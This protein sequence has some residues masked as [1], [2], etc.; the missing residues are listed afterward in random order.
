MIVLSPQMILRLW[1][2]GRD[3]HRWIGIARKCIVLADIPRE[4]MIPKPRRWLGSPV[5]TEIVTIRRAATAQS[6]IVR[7]PR[8]AL[9][10]NSTAPPVPISITRSLDEIVASSILSRDLAQRYWAITPRQ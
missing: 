6:F 5:P 2:P 8:W 10:F 3:L 7:W 4:M 1:M 9:M